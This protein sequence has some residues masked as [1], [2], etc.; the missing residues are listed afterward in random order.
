MTSTF[1]NRKE[2]MCSVTNFCQH[3]FWMDHTIL[4][5]LPQM[6]YQVTRPCLSSRPPHKKRIQCTCGKQYACI[7]MGEWSHSSWGQAVQNVRG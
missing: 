6:A 7:H 2:K 4:P 3:T 1:F 5:Y